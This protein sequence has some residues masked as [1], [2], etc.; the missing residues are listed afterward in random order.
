[1]IIIISITILRPFIQKYQTF[2][3]EKVEC[4]YPLISQTEL[5]FVYHLL[6]MLLQILSSTLEKRSYGRRPACSGVYWAVRDT[7]KIETAELLVWLLSPGQMVKTRMFT[8]NT[9]KTEAKKKEL[10]SVLLQTHPQVKQS[11]FNFDIFIFIPNIYSVF[12]S[13]FK[14][15]TD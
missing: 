14:S 13:I 4:S 11:D 12:I 1:M 15:L 3:P 5:N 2:F 7:L 9:L 6:P 8:I 10:I